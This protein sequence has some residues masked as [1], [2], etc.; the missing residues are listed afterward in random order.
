MAAPPRLSTKPGLTRRFLGIPWVFAVVYSM[1]GLSIYFALGLVADRG[2]ALTPVIFLVAG[3]L[4][5]LTTLTYVEGALMYL[6][7]GGSSMF[8]RYGFNEFVSFAAGW[9]ILIDYIIIIAL[10]A[11]SV[12]HYLT[13]ISASFGD[14]PLELLVAGL[15][16]AL[17][18][19][20]NIA[21]FT[22]RRRQLLLT[23]VAIGGVVLL[24][25]VIAV[26]AITSFDP[27][28][29]TSGVDLFSSPSLE[30]LVYAMV[31][32]T[33][34]YAG[35]E[36]ASNLVP[37][38]EWEPADLPRLVGAGAVLVPVIYTGI[39][40]VALMAVPVRVTPDG[41]MTPLAGRFIE[42]PV[43]GV[44]M[45][46]EPG[47]VSSVMQVAVVAVAPAVLLW[48]ASTAMLGLSRHVYAL[49]TNRQIPSWL[50]KLDRRWSTPSV[51]IAIGAVM[52][53][54]LVIPGD[55]VFLAGVY[56]FGALLAIVIAHASILRLRVTD[57]GRP[58]PYRV[59]L[60]VTIRRW[61]LPLPALVAGGLTIAAWISVIAFHE[62][63]RYLGGGWMVF[64]LV[65]YVIYRN[66][67][68]QTSLTKRVTVPERA[69]MKERPELA[70]GRI[71]VP[72]FG[73]ALD[74][75]IVGTAGRLAGAAGEAGDDTPKVDLLYVIELPLTV[76]LGAHPPQ[77]MVEAAGRALERA[78]DAAADNDS[79]E[80]GTSIVRARSVGSGIVGEARRRGV[81]AI[82]MGAEPPTR[83]RGGSV[84]G[85]RGGTRPQE[86]GP[87]TE[88]VLRNAPCPVLLTAPPED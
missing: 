61:R 83:I 58:R 19:A 53:F 15:V 8:A 9:A 22:G 36:A 73:S 80:V 14:S 85:G 52:A 56:A 77:G 17:V 49:A 84:L 4:F 60:D 21:G 20:A 27:G 88:Y 46:F 33:V 54:A 50:G 18:A 65:A 68:E 78:S 7:R 70:Y 63:A 30:D 3:V 13:P 25:A 66:V 45:S 64:G 47:W 2:L 39:A 5:V 6:E 31:I 69:L 62:G 23:L 34:A 26:G 10:A 59:P 57:P 40:V 28:A 44:V 41:P 75:D 35:V 51:A 38:L 11:I 12:P 82:V 29:L 32:A 55:V 37:D 71:L 16:I 48:A 79:I 76:P 87:A 81:D 86:I 74:D 42:E 1:I 67:V 72:V 43:L 24:A